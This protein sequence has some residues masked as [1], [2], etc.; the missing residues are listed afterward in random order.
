MLC[1]QGKAHL[2]CSKRVYGNGLLMLKLRRLQLLFQ[3]GQGALGCLPLC[4]L[5]LQ[6]GNSGGVAGRCLLLTL[7]SALCCAL[8]LRLRLARLLRSHLHGRP[9]ARLGVDSQAWW[10]ASCS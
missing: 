3:A 9:P 8:R 1:L 5:C 7:P 2:G 10:L 6:S 4:T